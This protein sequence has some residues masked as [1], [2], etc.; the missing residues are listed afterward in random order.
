MKLENWPTGQKLVSA[1]SIYAFALHAK[2]K[3]VKIRNPY[4]DLGGGRGG[5]S[6]P[7]SNCWAESKS[8]KIQSGEGGGR[9][10]EPTSNFWYWV[11]IC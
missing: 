4:P 11:Q 5:G 9:C 8:A 6:G 10:P 2:S 3:S 1:G 7:T